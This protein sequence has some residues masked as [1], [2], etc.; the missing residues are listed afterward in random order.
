MFPL[1]SPESE[2]GPDIIASKEE[3][4]L[5]LSAQLAHRSEFITIPPTRP[6]QNNCENSGPNFCGVSFEQYTNSSV[7]GVF[8]SWSSEDYIKEV[9][10]SGF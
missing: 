9:T 2:A 10:F 3:M 6:A 7:W 5:I 1:W 4:L 8:S